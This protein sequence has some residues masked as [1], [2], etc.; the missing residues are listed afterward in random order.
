MNIIC[1]SVDVKTVYAG[2]K[3]SK[4][5]VLSRLSCERAGTRFNTRGVDDDGNVANFVE[6][7]QVSTSTLIILFD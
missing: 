4:V 7:E 5:V 6:T 1:G 3:T 2:D